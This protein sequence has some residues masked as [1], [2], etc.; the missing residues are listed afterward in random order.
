ML[1]EGGVARIGFGAMRLSGDVP[2]RAA[3]SRKRAFQ[4]LDAVVGEGIN[5]IDTADTYGLGHNED[6]LG[7]YL[8]A[9]KGMDLGICT[10]VGQCH[11]GGGRWSPLGD[12]RYLRQQVYGS[13]QRLGV[14]RLAALLLHRIDPHFSAHEQIAVLEEF[15]E[16]GQTVAIGV[17]GVDAGAL[18]VLGRSHPITFVQNRQNLSTGVDQGLAVTCAELGVT[19]LAYAPLALGGRRSEFECFAERWGMTPQELSLRWALS[20]PGVLPIPG[21][22]RP[23]H[24]RLWHVGG[25]NPLPVAVLQGVSSI[26]NGGDL[27]A[28]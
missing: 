12:P 15:L 24:V 4:V 20:Q 7:R 10:K 28:S 2:F 5:F 3:P 21:S 8:R 13:L 14:D 6:L 17:S 16:R 9:R 11:D 19:L 27:D 18:A 23:G 22:S 25:L 26:I 1:T